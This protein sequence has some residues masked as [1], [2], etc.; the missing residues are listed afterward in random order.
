MITSYDNCGGEITFLPD[1]VV[2]VHVHLYMYMYVVI[3]IHYA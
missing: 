3:I 2:L 1:K